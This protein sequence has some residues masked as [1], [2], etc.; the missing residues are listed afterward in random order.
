MK[1]EFRISEDGSHTIYVPDLNEHYHS[2]NG[3]I[4]ESKHIFIEAAFRFCRKEEIRILEIGFGTGLNAILTHMEAQKEDR[5]VYYHAVEKYP[6][7]DDEAKL[8][9]YDS[10]LEPGTVSIQDFHDAEWEKDCRLSPNFTLHKESSDAREIKANGPFD[11]IYFDAFS[12]DVQPALWT[13]LV[14]QKIYDL[15]AKDGILTTYSVKGDVKRALRSVGFK[16]KR[17]PGPHGKRQIL[18]AMKLHS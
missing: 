3:A 11:V 4:A 6:L 10:V 5:K 18:R 17:I 9:N 16:V 14:F 8:L 2:I 13:P 12:P 15:T 7:M 1:R